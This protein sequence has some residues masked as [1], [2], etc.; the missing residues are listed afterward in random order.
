[1]KRQT[2]TLKNTKA[3]IEYLQKNPLSTAAQIAEGTGLK[4]NIYTTLINLVEKKLIGKNASRQ[5]YQLQDVQNNVS[6]QRET[7]NKY[8]NDPRMPVFQTKNANPLANIYRKEISHIQSGIDQ[9]VITKNYLE[10]RV[11]ELD[12]V[13]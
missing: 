11:E 9:L 13:R 6:P 3:V 7:E 10:R 4:G 5:Y 8:D 12:N 1:M 2:K